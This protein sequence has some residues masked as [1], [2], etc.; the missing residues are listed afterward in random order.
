MRRR[1]QNRPR[2]TRAA[3]I[4]AG[5][6]PRNGGA[7]VLR[8][9][10]QSHLHKHGT[11]RGSESLRT[12]LPARKRL[13]RTRQCSDRGL[14]SVTPKS[15]KPDATQAPARQRHRHARTHRHHLVCAVSVTRRRGARRRDSP[16]DSPIRELHQPRVRR[17]GRHRVPVHCLRTEEIPDRSLGRIPAIRA[18]TP[19]HSLQRRH[20]GGAGN[21]HV[22]I[23]CPPPAP[24]NERLSLTAKCRRKRNLLLSLPSQRRRA[25]HFQQTPAR[26]NER[27]QRA[28]PN[29]LDAERPP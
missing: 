25:T 26:H 11:R 5:R 2:A 7:G 14:Q 3:L 8:T 10:R 22:N 23:P 13:H 1:M 27:A 6:P 18:N 20:I 9:R 21:R 4:P 24:P 28:P 15:R 17:P 19:R 12:P 29:A 16:C